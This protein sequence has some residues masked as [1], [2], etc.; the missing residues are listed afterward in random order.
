MKHAPLILSF[1]LFLSSHALGFGLDED[2]A[3]VGIIS[4]NQGERRNA[5]IALILD[6][7]SRK[8]L[9]L[10]VGDNLPGTGATVLKIGAKSVTVGDSLRKTSL[11]RDAFAGPSA[12]VAQKSGRTGEA[13]ADDEGLEPEVADRPMPRYEPAMPADHPDGGYYSNEAAGKLATNAPQGKPVRPPV[14]RGYAPSAGERVPEPEY[15]PVPPPP[16]DDDEEF[17]Y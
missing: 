15:P 5:S 16:F 3:L 10:R 9:V 2:F 1:S 14:T 6:K 8:N 12:D 13:P 11:V 7:R 17:D 4:D